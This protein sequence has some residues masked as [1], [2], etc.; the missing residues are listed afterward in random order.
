MLA[1]GVAAYIDWVA[2]EKDKHH[3]RSPF[4]RS[5]R[6]LIYYAW[7]RLTK[8]PRFEFEH[9]LQNRH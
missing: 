9:I 8:G 2:I 5:G 1:G 4:A 6:R 7:L 3:T